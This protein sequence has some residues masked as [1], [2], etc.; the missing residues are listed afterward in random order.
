M[1]GSKNDRVS[2]VVNMGGRG[3]R[4]ESNHTIERESA[5][6]RIQHGRRACK[7]SCCFSRGGGGGREESEGKRVCI[8]D[9][10]AM[11]TITQD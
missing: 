4:H 5:R 1:P 8:C 6:E 2:C 9:A 7:H 10:E 11:A 3:R